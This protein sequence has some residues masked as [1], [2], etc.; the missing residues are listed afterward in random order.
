MWWW[1]LGFLAVIVLIAV[2]IDRRGSTG[3]SRAE[4]R[5]SG[6]DSH[7]PDSGYGA[8]GFGGGGGDGGG[9]F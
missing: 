5:A 1:I 4:D 6:R 3:A 8:G 7:T 9:G 2:V